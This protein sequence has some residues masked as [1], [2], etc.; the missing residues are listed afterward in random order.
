M[1]KYYDVRSKYSDTLVQT[2][3]AFIASQSEL[4]DNVS[5]I[6]KEYHVQS[7]KTVTTKTHENIT[8]ANL[9]L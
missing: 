3:A 8:F 4:L 5:D 1:L 9:Q 2:E 7:W 6:W